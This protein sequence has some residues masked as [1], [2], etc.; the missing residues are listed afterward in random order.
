VAGRKTGV[1]PY[2]LDIEA[3]ITAAPSP[4]YIPRRGRDLGLDASRRE[5]P[6]LSHVEAAKALKA[7]LGQAW[8]AERYAWLVQRY[9]DG[10]PA[11]QIE[12]IAARLATPATP[13]GS[14]LKVVGGTAC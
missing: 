5:I 3:D 1:A 11:D 4:A 10:V 13:A 14:V 12:E 7:A 6:P 9:P 8:N 2:G